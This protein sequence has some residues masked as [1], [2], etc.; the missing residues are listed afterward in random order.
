[1]AYAGRARQDLQELFVTK[2]VD[3][4]L[5]LKESAYAA[6]SLGLSFVGQCNG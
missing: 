2:I 6:L 3:T 5:S 1:M 4:S